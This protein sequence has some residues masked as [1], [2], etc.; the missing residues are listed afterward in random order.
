M[1]RRLAPCKTRAEATRPLK[2][3]LSNVAC[4]ALLADADAHEEPLRSRPT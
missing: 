2:R 3:H 1:H 4:R